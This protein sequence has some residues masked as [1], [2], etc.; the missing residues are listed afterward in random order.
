[1]GLK[2]QERNIVGGTSGVTLRLLSDALVSGRPMATARGYING[3][4]SGWPKAMDAWKDGYAPFSSRV[5]IP[6][7]AEV[8]QMKR[9]LFKPIWNSIKYVG[10]TM[11]ALDL[12]NAETG[13]EAFATVLANEAL[14]VNRWK[15]LTDPKYAKEQR[16]LVKKYLVTDKETVD[17][18]KKEIEDDAAEFGYSELDKR[19]ILLDKINRLRPIETT[20]QA[21]RFGVYSTGNV[22]SFGTV[23]FLSDKIAD[24]L[25]GVKLTYSMP[26]TGKQKNNSSA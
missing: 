19:M 2:T 26:K 21:A 16:E 20:E 8:F 22:D 18:L 11:N 15:A 4:T 3:I 7:T 1:M 13:K 12:L 9:G 10:R 14:K 23:G 6:S 25:K 5:E 17:R 24:A